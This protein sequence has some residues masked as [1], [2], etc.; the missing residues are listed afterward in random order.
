MPVASASRAIESRSSP[1]CVARAAA[2]SRIAFR[3]R[4]PFVSSTIVRLYAAPTRKQA[5]ALDRK[6]RSFYSH[7][8]ADRPPH[9]S[10]AQLRGRQAFLRRCARAA[11]LQDPARLAR[12]PPRVLRDRF[13]AELA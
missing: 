5:E 7:R 13:A 9:D 10:G 3:V 11:R 6:A 2:A 1:S 12:P 8:H 4:S